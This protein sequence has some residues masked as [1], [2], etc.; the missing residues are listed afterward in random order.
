MLVLAHRGA[1]AHA[2]ENTLEAFREAMAQNADGVE[3]DVQRCGSGELVV[4]HDEKLDRLAGVN[5]DLTQTSWRKLRQADVGSSLGFGRSRIP[6]LEE[7]LDLLPQKMLINIE[8]KCDTAEDKGLAVATADLVLRRAD[9]KRVLFSSFNALCL[10]RAAAVAPQ[11]KRGY[12]IDPDKNHF[13]HANVLASLA[14][15]YSIHPYHKTLTHDR[16][17]AWKKARLKVAT[18][19]VNDPHRA[20]EL[21]MMGVDVVITDA[22]GVLKGSLQGL[23]NDRAGA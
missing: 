17:E 11:I 3:L 14:G 18:W 6:L 13:V 10:F 16:V 22:P 4:C 23:S 21:A 7:V 1:S 15:N 5:W 19:T 9:E 20:A 12:L 2:P 8:L